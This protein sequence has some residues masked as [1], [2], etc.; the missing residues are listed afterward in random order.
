MDEKQ[1][2]KSELFVVSSNFD[3]YWY[4]VCE[5]VVEGAEESGREGDDGGVC[6]YVE[7]LA[8]LRRADLS[9]E[10]RKLEC[11]KSRNKLQTFRDAMIV[12]FLY[13]IAKL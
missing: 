1:Q 11:S 8:V 13:H 10:L 5:Q 9:A 7:R 4:S 6:L 2:H 3:L 12:Q